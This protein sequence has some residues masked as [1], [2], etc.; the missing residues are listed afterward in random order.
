M[1][2]TLL[3]D[4]VL[5]MNRLRSEAFLLDCSAL[6]LQ[7]RDEALELKE[8]AV[9]LLAKQKGVEEGTSLSSNRCL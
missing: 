1:K 3:L 6:V 8:V 5:D 2:Y 9:S 4:E 7:K